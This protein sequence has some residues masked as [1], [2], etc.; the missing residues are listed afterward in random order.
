[1]PEDFY[2]ALARF[3]NALSVIV[4]KAHPLMDAFV[5]LGIAE[6]NEDTERVK[7]AQADRRG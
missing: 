2:E 6:L 3:F 4:E 7:A 1:M 5:G